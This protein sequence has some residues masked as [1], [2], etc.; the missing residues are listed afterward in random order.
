[1]S[2]S[3]VLTIDDN[4]GASSNFPMEGTDQI[5]SFEVSFVN[6][7]L[8]TAIDALVFSASPVT[9]VDGYSGTTE[10]STPGTALDTAKSDTKLC[11]EMS[12]EIFL[13]ESDT[14][15]TDTYNSSLAVI[16]EETGTYTV[17]FDSTVDLS[18][19]DD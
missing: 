15:I 11:G 18:V 6:P 7:C 2:V 4:N 13:D 19:I 8:T 16:S 17:T 12:F 3:V 9:I 1:M 5:V 14:P 10:F